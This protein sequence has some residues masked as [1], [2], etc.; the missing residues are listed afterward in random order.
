MPAIRIRLRGTLR[1][2][3]ADSFAI[4]HLPQLLTRLEDR[5][6][7]PDI[8]VSVN[9]SAIIEQQLRDK[10]LDV[11]FVTNPAKKRSVVAVPLGAINFGLG[12][13]AP[14]HHDTAWNDHNVA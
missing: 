12:D 14:H 8:D 13:G 7:L 11:A 6:P 4:S 5:Y 10:E 3:T 1:T 2:G 9:F